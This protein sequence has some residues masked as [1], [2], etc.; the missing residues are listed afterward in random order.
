MT[1]QFT[2]KASQAL[3]NIAKSATKS[4]LTN[5]LKLELRGNAR[6]CCPW[7]PDNEI[8][9]QAKPVFAL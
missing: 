7:N 2:I 3:K 9:G 5:L 1:N 6:D 8:V 4:E